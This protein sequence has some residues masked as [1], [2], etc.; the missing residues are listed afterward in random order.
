MRTAFVETLVEMAGKDDRIFLLTGDL[1]W[2]VLEPFSGK[3]PDRFVNVGV[4][5]ADMTGI[6]TGLALA[7][8]VPFTYSIAT[9]ASMRPYEQIRNGPIQHRLPVRVIG[10][11]GG[12]AYGHAGVSH[13]ALEDLAIMR[14]QPGMTVI[15]PADPAQTRAALHAIRDLAGPVYMRVGKGGNPVVP[16]LEGRFAFGRPEMVREGT[17]L[18]YLCTGGTVPDALEASRLL[19]GKGIRAAVAV[20]A[21]LGF[22]GSPELADLLGR[23]PAVITVEEGYVTG[24]LGSLVAETM[25]SRRLSCRLAVKG[26]ERSPG[27]RSGGPEFMRAGAGLDSASLAAAASALLD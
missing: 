9:F 4:A 24:G 1:G 2:S 7:G 3:Y 21:H 22:T 12:F 26:V 11:G 20:L 27:G 19:E 25:A 15:A 6:A 8:Y 17:A 5:E 14:C 16:G 10:T 13:F 23:F 18:L